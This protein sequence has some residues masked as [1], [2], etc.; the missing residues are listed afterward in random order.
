LTGV[1][2]KVTEVPEQMVVAEAAMLTL[3][4]RLFVT[5]IVTVLDVAGL[6]VAHPML[7]V[8]SQ[9]TASPLFKVLLVNVALFEPTD[10]PLTYHAYTGVVPPLTAVAVK[11][12]GV[13]SQMVPAG[14]AVMLMLT[15]CRGATSMTTVLDVAGLPVAQVAF[16][17]T[18]QATV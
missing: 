15:G 2:V 3:T 4:A 1:A 17:V 18:T 9:V 5:D 16:D 14:E 12:T 8:S 10:T 13:P 11:V 7:E 6:P